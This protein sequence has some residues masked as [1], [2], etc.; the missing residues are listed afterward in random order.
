MIC[1]PTG[2]L[3]AEQLIG[4]EGVI[5]ADIDLS[6]IIEQKEIHDILGYYNRFDVF[7]L[8]VDFTPNLPLWS[9]GLNVR[10]PVEENWKEADEKR[11]L[12][13]EKNYP[14]LKWTRNE[15]L[16]FLKVPLTKRS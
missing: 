8:E 13:N 4:K 6:L 7:R 11:T 2:E 15:L 9:K 16:Q 3:I 5:V 12:Q 14:D 1:G 10:E